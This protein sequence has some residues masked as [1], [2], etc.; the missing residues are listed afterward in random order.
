M[1]DFSEK[2]FAKLIQRTLLSG[3]FLSLFFFFLG[4]VFRL[5]GPL[6][7]GGEGFL[8]TGVLLLALTPAARVAMLIY[9]YCRTREYHFA[10]AAFTVLGLLLVSALI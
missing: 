4:F 2:H 10:L 7:G 9:G 8:W 1:E 5:S 3:V 6:P